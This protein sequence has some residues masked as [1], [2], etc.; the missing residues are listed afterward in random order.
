MDVGLSGDGTVVNV[1]PGATE[2]PGAITGPWVDPDTV[3]EHVGQHLAGFLEE[4]HRIGTVGPAMAWAPLLLRDFLVGGK[5]LRPWLCALGWHATG[6]QEATR[7]LVGLAAGLEMFHTFA[8]IHDDVMDRSV[9][10]RGRPTLHRLLADQLGGGRPRKAD[11]RLGESA[12][13]LI[14]DLALSWSNTLIQQAGLTRAQSARCLPLVERMHGEVVSGQFMDLASAGR[15]DATM[16]DAL[17]IARYK[18]AGYTFERPLQ[19]GAAL[20]DGAPEVTEVLSAY[21]IP[22]GYA[23]QVRDDLLGVFGDPKR[24]GKSRL[25]DL[26]GGKCTVLLT[27]ARERAGT[28]QRA[29]LDELVGDPNLDEEGAARVRTVLDATGARQ[30]AEAMIADWREQARS[31]VL[32]AAFPAPARAALLAL[33]DTATTRDS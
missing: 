8:L 22:L 20:A 26:R 6:G 21:A 19:L 31:A 3:R 5:S 10:R 33:A 28:V 27:T 15:P 30:E 32:R 4:Q 17:E 7:Q 25:E 14:G 18:T 29:V 11:D 13:I 12:A 2:V 24:T 9:S 16:A 1:M 23:F